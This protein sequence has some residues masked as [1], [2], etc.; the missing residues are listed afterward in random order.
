MGRERGL[1][2]PKCGERICD[3]ILLA[4]V[5]IKGERAKGQHGKG[6][7]LEMSV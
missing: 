7:V 3:L 2:W 1:P 4:N 6:D 5:R